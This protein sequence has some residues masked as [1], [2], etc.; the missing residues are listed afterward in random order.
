MAEEQHFIIRPACAADIEPII[1]LDAAVTATPKPA[2]WEA[3]FKDCQSRR[4]QHFLLVAVKD[5]VLLGFI[6][7]E[8]RAWEFGSP[9]CGWV[10]AIAV[11]PDTRLSGMGADL[12]QAI[13]D[14]F[15]R[16]GITK[17][18]TMVARDAQLVMSFFRAQGMMA[19]PFVELE[20]DLDE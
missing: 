12:F 14:A 19:G 17:V 3:L 10:F 1:R 20:K 7:G 5:D 2:Y 16:A 13:C 15:R 6:A 11:D 18:R 8:I 9:P 4:K